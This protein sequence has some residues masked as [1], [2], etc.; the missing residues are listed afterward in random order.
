MEGNEIFACA[1]ESFGC[2][3][4]VQKPQRKHSGKK[5]SNYS[6][7]PQ[8]LQGHI[9]NKM[10]QGGQKKNSKDRRSSSKKDHSHDGSSK[11]SQFQ[12]D[13]FD[14]NVRDIKSDYKKFN[15]SQDQLHKIE[16]VIK[17][18]RRS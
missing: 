10:Y 15:I 1:Q 17:T 3:I 9:F 18:R 14:K 4:Y 6:N 8:S 5:K 7:I 2:V 12:E 11:F 16:E 13:I